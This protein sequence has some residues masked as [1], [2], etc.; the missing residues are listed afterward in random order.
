MSNAISKAHLDD[1]E[2]NGSGYRV[3]F[4]MV[5]LARFMDSLGKRF[6]LIL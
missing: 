1:S 3:S 2:A 5:E 4:S 6:S